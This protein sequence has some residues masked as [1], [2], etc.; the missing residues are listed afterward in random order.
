MAL[1][2]ISP[3]FKDCL[4]K[5]FL[6]TVQFVGQIFVSADNQTLHKFLFFKFFPFLFVLL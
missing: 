6:E 4:E 1:R 2:F 3:L 5:K